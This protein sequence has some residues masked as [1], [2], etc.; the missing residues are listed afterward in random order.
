MNKKLDNISGQELKEMIDKEVIALE[1]LDDSALEKLMSYETE[2]LCLGN[3]DMT[4]ISRCATLLNERNSSD[5]LDKEKFFSVIEKTKK[6]RVKIIDGDSASKEETLKVIKKRKPIFRK[7]ALI[8][9]VLSVMIIASALVSCGVIFDFFEYLAK[10]AREPVG[11]QI[12]ADGITFY[13]TGESK[14]YTSIEELIE[15]ENLDI[16]YPT[17]WPEGVG[18]ERVTVADD[19]VSEKEIGIITTDKNIYITISINYE[20]EF[21]VQYPDEIVIVNDW[22]FYILDGYA[23]CYHEGNC[24]SVKTENY[25]DLITII[26]SFKE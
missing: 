19:I 14:E 18:I 2:M 23:M 24:Y 3:G 13:N 17:K 16:M 25:N 4:I 11:T 15:K 21:L 9:A 22:E 26:K 20:P 7:G 1:E 12:T 8:A 10:I 6:E 5:S